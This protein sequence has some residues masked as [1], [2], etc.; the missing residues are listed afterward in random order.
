L[1][2]ET[3]DKYWN[4]RWK[5]YYDID[6]FDPRSPPKFG[7]FTPGSII[8]VLLDMDRG[9][10]NF[11]KDGND[12]GQAFIHPTLKEGEFYPFIQV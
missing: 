7:V 4:K 5:T 3:G 12:L 6:E 2:L 1:N 10:L 8:G 9:T 11:Y